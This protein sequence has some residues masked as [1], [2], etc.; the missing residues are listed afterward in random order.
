MNE[1]TS[2]LLR[3]LPALVLL[4]A[5]SASSR[6]AAQPEALTVKEAIERALER[7]PGLAVAR[8]SVE[9]GAAAARMA[10]GAGD[11][12]FSVRT[13]PGYAT[14]IPTAVAGQVPAIAGAMVSKRIYDTGLSSSEL[15]AA[16]DA[17]AAKGALDRARLE[18][19]KATL[20]AYARCRADEGVVAAARRRSAA[21]EAL[22]AQAA[23]L[24]REGRKTPLDAE[25]AALAA[26]QARQ[27]LLDAESDRDL[28]FRELTRLVGWPAGFPLLLT[29]DV[30]D[31]LPAPDP[32]DP[33]AVAKESDPE[34][35]ALRRQ[36]ESLDHA[37]V[38]ES[39]TLRPTIDAEA[40]YMRLTRAN[41][42]DD[43]YVTFK[44]DNFVVGVSVVLPLFTGG[45]HDAEAAL[46]KARAAE[47]DARIREREE[48]VVGAVARAE[49][50]AG[51]AF[52]GLALARR[53]RGV[54]EESL[55][56]ARLVAG[57]G[58]GDAGDVE[59]AETA[60]SEA[61][62]EAARAGLALVSAR[63]DSALA[64]GRLPSEAM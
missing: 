14:G 43:Y 17:A 23:A 61:E 40:Q 50:A 19:V 12:Q 53:A 25:R 64:A 32:A 59:R 21:Q 44:A 8:A 33:A 4:P 30:L 6:A 47:V 10:E 29:G 57:E 24:A 35:L 46:A 58:R 15:R 48:S 49:A 27:G 52:A 36:K 13:T 2:L 9:E 3:S 63:V 26:A 28:D 16:S 7:S 55:R 51:R 56:L 11:F 18:T 54:A 62:I 1:R 31:A 39:R 20:L 60:L 42:Y 22:A 38:L 37:A 45:R 41:N 34:L 5:L